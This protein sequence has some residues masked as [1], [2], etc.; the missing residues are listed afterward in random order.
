[1]S[2]R[3]P[4]DFFD[5]QLEWDRDGQYYHYLTQWM[6]ALNHMSVVT[7]EPTF[8]LWAIELAKTAHARFIYNPKGGGQKRMYWKMSIDLKYPLVTSMGQ[9]DPV[10]GLITYSELQATAGKYSRQSAWPDLAAEIADIAG[11][12]QGKGLVTDDPLG[13]GGLLT[14]AFKIAR[15]IIAGNFTK[16]ELLEVVAASALTGL[17]S[18]VRES[19]LNLPADY[20]LAFR[21]LGLSIGL[22][23]AQR[24]KDLLE[25][26]PNVFRKFVSMQSLLE[27]LM[28]YVPLREKINAFWLE[29][30][31]RES[32]VWMAHRDI[33]MVMLATSLAPQG[34]ISL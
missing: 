24:L 30:K 7:G 18:Y 16:P 21:E 26:Y 23:A 28:Q 33:N 8:N 1:M 10:D 27:G 31:N 3:R 13:L 2:E 15:L 29:R 34:Y 25:Q 12:S 4:E 17:D 22:E 11:I 6:H 5:E 19:S 20:R 32:A 14:G 9:H